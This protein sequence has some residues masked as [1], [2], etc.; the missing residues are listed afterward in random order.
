MDDLVEQIAAGRVSAVKVVLTSVVA[1]LAFYQVFLMA[2]G[3]GKLRLRVLAARPASRTHRAVGDTVASVTLLVAFMC[4][5]YFGVEDGYEHAAPGEHDRVV[6]HI[7]VGTLLVAVLAF[8]IA[9]LRW[10]HRFD[11]YLPV[12]GLSVFTLFVLTWIT[13]SGAVL[14]GG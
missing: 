3:Y 7:A 9:V 14:A 6:W 13:S 5:A 10:W 2:V 1:A 8:K 4:L 11:R 12:L